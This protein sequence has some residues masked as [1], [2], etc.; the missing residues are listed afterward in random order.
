MQQEALYVGYKH[1][2]LYMQKKK[3]TRKSTN[4]VEQQTVSKF[5][6]SIKSVFQ[7]AGLRNM[8]MQEITTTEYQTK[9]SAYKYI[10]FLQ[11]CYIQIIT[12]LN[13]LPKH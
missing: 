1:S 8:G 13:T 5:C 12:D 6:T 10:L 11:K 2:V 4:S 9:Y 7:P 3:Q